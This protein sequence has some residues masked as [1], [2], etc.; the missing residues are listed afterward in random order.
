MQG[1]LFDDIPEARFWD[2][3][4]VTAR[5]KAKQRLPMQ[6]EGESREEYYLN[7]RDEARLEFANQLRIIADA[8]EQKTLARQKNT[9]DLLWTI[10]HA[11]E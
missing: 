8:I 11:V 4:I 6:M 7:L 1:S 10:K 5:K 9:I 2:S 3:V